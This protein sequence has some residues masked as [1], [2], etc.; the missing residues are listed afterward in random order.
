MSNEV[1]A[2]LA[3]DVRLSPV[4]NAN[5]NQKEQD[6]SAIATSKNAVVTTKKK[7]ALRELNLQ[8]S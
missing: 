8:D 2:K 5:C 4:A 3:C 7:T 1:D 6:D